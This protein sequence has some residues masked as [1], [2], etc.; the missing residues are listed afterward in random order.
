MP[1][2]FP[3]I[4]SPGQGW[5]LPSAPAFSGVFQLRSRAKVLSPFRC[6]LLQCLLEEPASDPNDVGAA[7]AQV[8]HPP[9]GVAAATRPARQPEEAD[10]EA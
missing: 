1:P 5:S 4:S 6:Q 2:R 7:V 10:L 9:M 8:S 3:C